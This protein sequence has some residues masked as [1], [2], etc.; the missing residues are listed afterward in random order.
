M[1]NMYR[2]TSDN[3]YLNKT[4]NMLAENVPCTFK[5]DTSAVEPTIIISPDAY[6]AQ[7]NYVYLSDT[8]RYYYVVDRVFSQQRVELKLSVDVRS[9]FDFSNCD[10]IALRSSNKFNTY[11]NDP[12]YP[13]VQFAN[14]VLKA[15]PNSFNNHLS[16]VLTI[17]GGAGS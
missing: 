5:D 14:P 17:A 11:L 1:L 13:H 4:L 15:F 10:C 9:S 3:R 7:C 16:A 6:D 8:E 2:N 12:R